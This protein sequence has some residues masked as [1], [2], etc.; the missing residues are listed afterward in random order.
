MT[1]LDVLRP[2]IERQLAELSAEAERLQAALGA[3]D[4]AETSSAVS[5]KRG[6]SPA[7]G[8]RRRAG[9]RSN[10]HGSVLD[11][12]VGEEPTI[13]EIVGMVAREQDGAVVGASKT[14]G[15]VALVA[16]ATVAERVIAELRSE[17]TA[18]LRNGRG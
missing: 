11:A 12:P 5:S 13:G 1:D 3:L 6:E 7:Q 18:G 8:V 17:L 10:S 2:G 14:Q 16:P 4:G 9:P 15:D